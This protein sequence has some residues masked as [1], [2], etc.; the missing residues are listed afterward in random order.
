MESSADQVVANATVKSAVSSADQMEAGLNV[1]ALNASALNAD[2]KNTQKITQSNEAAIDAG[3]ATTKASFTGTTDHRHQLTNHPVM[4]STV[5]SPR[6]RSQLGLRA[7]A[8]HCWLEQD[9]V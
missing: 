8:V 9:H 4:V 2:A 5:Q 3:N 7:L 1:A 6:P